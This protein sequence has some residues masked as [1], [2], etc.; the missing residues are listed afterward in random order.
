[1]YSSENLERF[2]LRYKPAYALFSILDMREVCLFDYQ[3]D[4]VRRILEAF[5]SHVSVMVQMPMGTGKTHVLVSVVAHALEA[6]AGEVWIVSH[7]R[8]LVAQVEATAR[9]FGL[10]PFSTENPSGRIRVMSVQWLTHHLCELLP[11]APS[12]LVVD[13]AHHAVAQTYKA[14]LE[15]FPRA[16]KLGVTATPCRLSGRGFTDLFEVLLQSWPIARFIAEGRLA[17]YEY[18]SVRSDSKEQI[19]IASLRSRNA[20]GDFSTAEM[21]ELLDVRPS[22]ECLRDS[23]L[24]YAAGRKG[25]VYAIDIRHAEHVASCY[26]ASGIPAVVISSH[27][28]PRL[29]TALIERFR[30]AHAP[31]S[32]EYGVSGGPIRVLVSVDLFGEG[33]DCPDVGFV[34]LARPTL[35]LARYLQM[36]GRGLRACRGKD[37][38]IV[39][40][41]VGAY[42]LFGLPSAAR[43]WQAMFEGRAPAKDMEVSLASNSMPSFPHV[44]GDGVCDGHMELVTLLTHGRLLAQVNMACGFQVVMGADGRQGVVDGKGFEV[45]SPIYNKVELLDGGFAKLTSRMVSDWER[46]WVDLVNGVR[47]GVRPRVVTVG[48][49][50]MSTQDGLRLYPRV[51]TRLMDADSYVTPASVGLTSK[52]SL[53]FRGFCLHDG[54]EG[55]Q[56]YAIREIA[57]GF[58]LLADEEGQFYTQRDGLGTELSDLTPISMGEWK[59]MKRRMEGRRRAFEEEARTLVEPWRWR[60][61][62][63]SP[64]LGLRTAH[65]VNGR[66]TLLA[67]DGT[68]AEGL[69][70]WYEQAELLDGGFLYLR[71][72]GREV[73]VDLYT[74]VVYLRRPMYLMMGFLHVAKVGD[75]HFVRDVEE[76]YGK[77]F[78]AEDIVVCGGFALLGRKYI[79][80]RGANAGRL[81]TITKRNIDNMHFEV[82][83]RYARIYRKEAVIYFDGVHPPTVKEK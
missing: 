67:A 5:R 36:V 78:M 46:P 75:A 39:L 32:E 70:G 31:Y 38:C 69:S 44:D 22:V 27:T 76:L 71:Q 2:S 82:T 37:Y 80:L 8:E 33:F 3:A 73:W 11:S 13:E 66:Y 10:E 51:R 77:P 72:G 14:V 62:I 28:P 34:Q 19:A 6:H 21:S 43:D 30:L 9:S 12:L 68:R 59:V 1:M 40:D 50:E 4:M 45:L 41:N 63:S 61:P 42:R 53:C 29:R 52:Q 7:R 16:R 65:A 47:F 81:Y 49:W 25:I 35:S 23:V 64:A 24:R 60:S 58:L 56:L 79:L 15:A 54:A 55:L 17:P 48:G 20:D 83:Y 57:E 26:R 74:K 18:L